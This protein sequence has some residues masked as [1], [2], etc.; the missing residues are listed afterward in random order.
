M[1]C[2]V[3]KYSKYCTIID[4]SILKYKTRRH[5]NYNLTSLYL[6]VFENKRDSFLTLGSCDDRKCNYASSQPYSLS[7]YLSPALWLHYADIVCF[8]KYYI[9][10][11]IHS[12]TLAKEAIH[13]YWN[14]IAIVRFVDSLNCFNIEY[15]QLQQTFWTLQM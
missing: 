12:A 8:N 1:T 14:C 13:V 9:F 5:I 10:V 15:C 6:C 11:Y 3:L 2:L 4:E 7:L